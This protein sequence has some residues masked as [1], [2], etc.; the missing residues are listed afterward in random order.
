MCDPASADDAWVFIEVQWT[1][2]D[3]V[4][5]ETRSGQRLPSVA[6]HACIVG[7]RQET[8]IEHATTVRRSCRKPRSDYSPNRIRAKHVQQA[9]V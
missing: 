8:D 5:S 4:L 7:S 2:V 6:K 1:L 9:V 3:A